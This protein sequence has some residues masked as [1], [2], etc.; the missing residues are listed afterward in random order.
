MSKKASRTKRETAQNTGKAK[1]ATER[2]KSQGTTLSAIR[3]RFIAHLKRT[4]VIVAL[5][6]ACATF[7]VY[8]PVADYEFIW[9][10]DDSLYVADN[11]HV[12]QGLTFE[13]LRW[14][15][16]A[17]VAANWHPLTLISHM[18]D[19][20]LFGVNAGAHHIVNVVFHV[21][22]TV[23]LFLLLF[24]VTTS[25][26]KSAFVAALF[27]LHPLHV[28]SVAWIAER[29]DVLSTIFWL[30]STKAYVR[31]TRTLSHRDYTFTAL[32]FA[33]GLMAK[34]MLVTLPFTF[35]LIDV[36]PLERLRGT[37]YTKEDLLAWWQ[38]TVEKIPLFVMSIVSSIITLAFQRSGG[39]R[40]MGELLSTYQSVGNAIVSYVKYLYL[41]VYPIPLAVFYPHPLH[42]LQFSAVVVSAFIL[43]V[44][45]ILVLVLAK[46]K[47][48]LFMGWFWYIGTLLPVIGIV[49]VGSQ[50]L[51]D[52][53]TYVPLTGIFIIITWGTWDILGKTRLGRIALAAL[54]VVVLVLLSG[55]TLFQLRFWKN[56][57]TLFRRALAVTEDNYVAHTNLGGV[58]L[59]QGKIDEAKEHFQK[60][61]E[62]SPYND[63]GY[64][65]MGDVCLMQRRLED[66]LRYYEKV[67]EITPD[68]PLARYKRG[69]I[70]TDL[71]RLDEALKNLQLGIEQH[72]ENPMLH[73]ELS[74][75][76]DKLG[77]S[78][79]AAIHHSLALK[80]GGP[81]AA[82][83]LSKGKKGQINRAR[84]LASE[85]KFDEAATIYLHILRNDPRSVEA[86][87][88]LANIR[89]RQGQ[90][91][92]A[93][94]H[95]EEALKYQ[96]DNAS[97]HYNMA[98]VYLRQGDPANARKHLER[99]LQIDPK[100]EKARETLESINKND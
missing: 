61:M 83:G 9:N 34:P 100:F 70:L 93:L 33:L 41:M 63:L 86:H 10:Y 71:G 99:A 43:L 25:L 69:A 8:S 2:E 37:F 66:A 27:A 51:A 20:S 40:V 23:L 29:K 21:A 75:V 26:W 39:S 79:E 6:L 91:E 58:L 84:A 65:G 4:E 13:N 31:Y 87:N 19:V 96:P 54:A 12:R 95:F 94:Q 1:P 90:Y 85:G 22:N 11:P 77:N 97:V 55:I 56:D 17:E 35:L 80:Y 59:E 88:N 15:L 14:A 30:L 64:Y 48:Y 50:A 45:T 36:W 28:Q 53:Y 47:P 3:H 44:V 98:H 38:R 76:L 46:K 74:R 73:E 89:A 49:Q 42:K 5:A 18:L 67:L 68:H 78:R 52:R 81:E 16:T 82:E 7:A 32:W 57:E 72:P 24:Q 62:I 92:E 60:V